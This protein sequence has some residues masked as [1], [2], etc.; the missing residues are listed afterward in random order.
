MINVYEYKPK[1]LLEICSKFN[2]KQYSNIVTLLLLTK[3]GLFR[4]SKKNWKLNVWQMDTEAVL[5]LPKEPKAQRMYSI[6]YYPHSFFRAD[7]MI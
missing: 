1:Q 5:K 4:T 7:M 3:Y 6:A 2:Q